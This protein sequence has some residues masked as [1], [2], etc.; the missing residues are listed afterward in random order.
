VQGRGAP[1]KQMTPEKALIEVQQVLNN[2][3]GPQYTVT[4]KPHPTNGT[5]MQYLCNGANGIW[6]S[7]N[8]PPWR[9]ER[10]IYKRC[11][12]TNGLVTR[13]VESVLPLRTQQQ[14]PSRATQT[15]LHVQCGVLDPLE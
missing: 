14:V 12:V 5:E 4:R 2:Q 15:T 7:P 6:L 3:E 8:G 11:V 10:D 13:L 1:L 9:V